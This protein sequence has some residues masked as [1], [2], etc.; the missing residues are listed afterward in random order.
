MGK[1]EFI[2]TWENSAYSQ[3][4]NYLDNDSVSI[5]M[6]VIPKLQ[7]LCYVQILKDLTVCATLGIQKV[8]L[9]TVTVNI[10]TEMM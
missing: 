1:N 4:C 8:F 6:A 7:H 9:E 2:L 10:Q 3:I 5:K